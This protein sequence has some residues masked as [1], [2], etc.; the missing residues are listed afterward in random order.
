M[1]THK[2]HGRPY[3]EAPRADELPAGTPAPYEP[4]ATAGE[5]RKANGTIAQGARAI[6]SA[7]GR[8]TKGTTK[9]SHRI[10]AP[11]LEERLQ[12]Q[13]RDLR[14]ALRRETAKN[15]GGGTCGIAASLLIKFAAQKT[16][17]AEQA[18]V[19]GDFETHRKLSESARMDLVYAREHAAKE[20]A[21]RP[22]LSRPIDRIYAELEAQK[23]GGTDAD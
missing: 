6:P 16:A 19:A 12:R 21:S 10:S 2:S 18:F 23:K 14:S 11:T 1:P 20:A 9:L 7:G 17:A 3:V 4:Q 22:A 5:E 8:A 13:A 15:V